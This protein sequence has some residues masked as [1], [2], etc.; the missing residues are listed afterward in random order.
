VQRS[1]KTARVYLPL[2]HLSSRSV[3]IRGLIVATALWRIPIFLVMLCLGASF[4][5]YTPAIGI[6]GATLGNILL[7]AIGLLLNCIVL[8]TLTVLLLAPVGTRIIQIVFLAWVI[9]V[10]YTSTHFDSVSQYL[11]VLR[12]PINPL[13]AC[14][15]IGLT[16]TA[17]I[18]DIA[19]IVLTVGYLLGLAT[20]AQ[21]WLSRRDL[22][23]N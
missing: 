9:I 14:Y 1:L 2:A 5:R 12:I 8:S 17:T 6:V 23:L 13:L 19:M 11:A 22:L 18:Y 15:M 10:L 21:F 20:L 3:Y 4:H 7:G 16:G